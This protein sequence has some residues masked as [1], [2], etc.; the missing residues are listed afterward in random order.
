MD[1]NELLGRMIEYQISTS[2]ELAALRKEYDEL[3]TAYRLQCVA[4]AHLAEQLRSVKGYVIN[5]KWPSREDLMAVLGIDDMDELT[6]TET[7]DDLPFGPENDALQT[8]AE[9]TEE[10]TA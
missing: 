8:A 10:M 4:N 7:V 1:D 2:K 5:N 3:Q 6:L 9:Q